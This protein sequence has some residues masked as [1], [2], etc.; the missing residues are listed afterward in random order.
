MWFGR[1]R[2]GI[3]WSL[4]PFV[5]VG[6]A[7]FQVVLT[8]TVGQDSDGRT[9]RKGFLWG[10]FRPRM[11]RGLID[12]KGPGHYAASGEENIYVFRGK[13]LYRR[14]ATVSQYGGI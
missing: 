11:R 7:G 4:G 13:T 2:D 5:P 14:S 12:R 3:Y 9:G 10:S 1:K 8:S 6:D